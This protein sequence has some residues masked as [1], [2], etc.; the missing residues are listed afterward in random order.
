MISLMLLTTQLRPHQHYCLAMKK[1]RAPKTLAKVFNSIMNQPTPSQAND[2]TPQQT[3]VIGIN[4]TI[5]QLQP[6]MQL[7][8]NIQYSR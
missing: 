3:R 6:R 4:N 1:T 7:I 5:F 8:K 2:T